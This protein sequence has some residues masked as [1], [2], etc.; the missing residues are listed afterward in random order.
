MLFQFF[1]MHCFP[2]LTCITKDRPAAELVAATGHGH[3][4]GFT[5]FQV[6]QQTAPPELCV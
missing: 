3:L 1:L 5:L 6:Q 4:G 2:L